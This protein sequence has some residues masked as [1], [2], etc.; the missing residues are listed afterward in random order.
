[1]KDRHQCE[2]IGVRHLDTFSWRDTQVNDEVRINPTTK[3]VI[4]NK[5]ITCIQNFV[6][7][8]YCWKLIDFW[9]KWTRRIIFFCLSFY[10]S[11]QCLCFVCYLSR[12][13]SVVNLQHKCSDDHNGFMQWQCS[14]PAQ[15]T[16]SFISGS[17][18]CVGG[19]DLIW[20]QWCIKSGYVNG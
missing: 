20:R 4:R 1:M 9:W 11:H 15:A 2:N 8:F 12:F 13:E 16:T 6:W 19:V 10:G 7:W 5:S 18:Q 14:D 3:H 17:D